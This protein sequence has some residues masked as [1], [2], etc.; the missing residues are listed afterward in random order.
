MRGAVPYT[1]VMSLLGVGASLWIAPAAEGHPFLMT[2]VRHRVNVTAGPR[3]ID[4]AVELTF[5]EL[6]SLSERRRMDRDH[7]GSL[8]GGELASYVGSIGDELDEGMRLTVDGRA[9]AVIPLYEPQLDL[10]GV[11]Q[12][13]PSHHVLRLSY[14][15]RTPA[16]LKEGSEL[17]LNDALWAGAPWMGAVEAAGKGGIVIEAESAANILSEEP[18][19]AQPRVLRARCRTLPEGWHPAAGV[20]E[21]TDETRV[22]EVAE[23]SELAGSAWPG[24]RARWTMTAAAMVILLLGGCA[25]DRVVKRK[26]RMGSTDH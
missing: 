1:G 18:A 15:A 14:F 17:A 21:L 6:R 5:H 19:D 20:R 12:V 10:L 23:A 9:V 22:A 26:T 13:A 8:D 4:I 24:W 16:W 3:N 11:E 7:D 2:Y 25:L